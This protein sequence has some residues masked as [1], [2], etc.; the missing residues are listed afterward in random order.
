MDWHAFLQQQSQCKPYPDNNNPA[1]IPLPT[2]GVLSIFGED[3]ASFLQNLL[4][5]DLR[6]LQPYYGQLTGLCNPKGRL[7]AI[8][9]LVRTDQGFDLLMPANILTSIQKKLSMFILRS[10]VTI[11]NDVENKVITG[12]I[13]EKP[14]S[15]NMP[16]QDFSMVEA[17]GLSFLKLPGTTARVMAIGSE[18]D[19]ASYIQTKLNEGWQ[20]CHEAVWQLNDIQ[21]GLP[22]IFPE[23]QERFTP[24]QVNLD[25]MDGVSFKKG[26][27]PGQEVVAR[28]HYLGTPSRRLFSAHINQS[29]VPAAGQDVTGQDGEVL[30]QVVQAQFDADNHVQLLL[31][32]KLA[33]VDK[34]TFIN[35]IAIKN[36]QALANEPE[37]V[38]K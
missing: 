2:W 4:T 13:T 38:S 33:E 32:M 25:L 3:A 5:N 15:I 20:L 22:F 34:A 9:I 8:F 18:K 28:L 26:C 12:V 6:S 36:L 1:L 24:Q 35:G 23:T 7:L 29:D 27:Y 16:E 37:M 10:K 14:D 19:S 11:T 17:D 31:T 30:G 21:A